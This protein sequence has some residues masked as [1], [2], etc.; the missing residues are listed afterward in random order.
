MLSA[1][2]PV[3]REETGYVNETYTDTRP[4]YMPPLAADLQKE[5]KEKLLESE[6]IMYK[7][8]A[9]IANQRQDKNMNRRSTLAVN[10]LM[11]AAQDG[12]RKNLLA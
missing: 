7:L 3:L 10:Y 8:G 1:E 2:K 11:A 4:I 12:E 9:G 5:L 6:K